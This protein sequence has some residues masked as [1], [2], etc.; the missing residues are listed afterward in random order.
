MCYSVTQ[1]R[2]PV[3]SLISP[4]LM[5]HSVP[6][7]YKHFIFCTLVTYSMCPRKTQV[8]ILY[9]CLY[10][11]LQRS[12]RMMLGG[13]WG[14]GGGEFICLVHCVGLQGISEGD[15]K[16]GTLCLYMNLCAVIA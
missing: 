3:P 1:N 16:V 14:R 2:E 9:C 4:D 7:L 6:N 13:L 12:K 11:G 8:D 10:K 5:Y 15:N